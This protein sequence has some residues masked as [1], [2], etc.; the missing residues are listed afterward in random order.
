MVLTNLFVKVEGGKLAIILVYIDDFIITSDNLAE[1]DQVKSNLL[2]RFHMKA[3]KELN[4]FLGLE[5]ERTKD[6]YSCILVLAQV[7]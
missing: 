3:L 7:F 6:G 5:V 2:V 4:Y 1:I